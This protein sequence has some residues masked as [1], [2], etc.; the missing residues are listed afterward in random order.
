MIVLDTHPIVLIKQDRSVDC[1]LVAQRTTARLLHLP[2]AYHPFSLAQQSLPGTV[3]TMS[4]PAPSPPP[5]RLKADVVEADE[6][7]VKALFVPVASS[8][9]A[10]FES[11]RKEKKR[12]QRRP[13]PDPYSSQDVMFHDVRDYLGQE[14]VDEL[15]ARKDDSEW[16]SP[17]GLELQKILEVRV[18]SFTVSGMS[19]LILLESALMRRRIIELVRGGREEMG[20]H[21]AFCTPRRPHPLQSIQTRPSR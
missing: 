2:I 19:T 5:K 10:P 12:K 4:S 18:G 7:P 8:S 9:K 6:V 17:A 13:L 3:R 1:M 20:N 15:L 16:H 11:K 21:Y 14:Y